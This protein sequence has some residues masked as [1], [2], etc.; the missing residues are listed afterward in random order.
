MSV[1]NLIN[2]GGFETGTLGG[3]TANN[4]SITTSHT[5]TGQY[6]AV[7]NQGFVASSLTQTVPISPNQS[8]LL[9]VSL[10]SQGSNQ[11]ILRVIYLNENNVEVGTG[12]D[13]NVPFGQLFPVSIYENWKEIYQ[14]TEPAPSTATK[15]RVEIIKP[16]NLSAMF[17]VVID[18]VVLLE[19]EGSDGVPG[20]TG[21]AGP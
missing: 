9:K 19:F 17:R 10:A 7:F 13:I 5:H 3:W 21:P 1:T 18:D 12:L 6:A 8:Y 14:V 16:G 15:A 11:I 2:N 4:T 20:P